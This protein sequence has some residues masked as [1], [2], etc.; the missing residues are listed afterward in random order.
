MDEIDREILKA[1]AQDARVSYR[2]LGA[3]VAL[4]ANATAERVR[5]LQREGVIAGFTTVID[6][7]ASGRALV[8]LI[9]VRIK[10]PAE[11]ER[12]ERLIAS[13]PEI[14][15]A[16]HVTGRYDY[17]LRVSCRDVTGLDDLIRT[18]KTHGGVLETDTRLALRSVLHR[19]SPIIS[20]DGRPGHP[21]APPESGQSSPPPST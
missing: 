7:V 20:G 8:A 1:L 17:Q 13:L 9:D 12:F 15:D 6:P 2:E 5:R 4:S 14:T 11:R 3:R 16:V 19:P 21:S 18:L 10:G